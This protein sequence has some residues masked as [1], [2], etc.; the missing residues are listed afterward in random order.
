MVPFYIKGNGKFKSSL[1]YCIVCVILWPR[2]YSTVPFCF[3]EFSEPWWWEESRNLKP[4]VLQSLGSKQRVGYTLM[5]KRGKK[6]SFLAEAIGRCKGT[7]E[8]MRNIQEND[9]NFP[10]SEEEWWNRSLEQLSS[11]FTRSC[12]SWEGMCTFSWRKWENS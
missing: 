8:G 9:R 10:K 1:H 12:M 6:H 7:K 5:E 2:L 3:L 11:H 4:T